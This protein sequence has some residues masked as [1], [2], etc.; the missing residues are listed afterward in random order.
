MAE[1]S[2]ALKPVATM[3]APTSYSSISLL[4]VEAEGVALAAGLDAALL[5]LAAGDLEADLGIDDGNRRH[6]L[7]EGDPHRLAQAEPLIERV[8]ELGL[9][10]HAAVD[11]LHAADAQASRRCTAACGGP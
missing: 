11:A 5:A 6:G 2:N 7:R 1:G 9:G 10:E 4:L 8:G 3:I